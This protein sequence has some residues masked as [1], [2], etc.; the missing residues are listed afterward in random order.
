M[1][2][3]LAK[4][5]ELIGTLDPEEA[6]T[7]PTPQRL[8]ALQEPLLAHHPL[9]PLAVDLAAQ[10]L[11]RQGGHHPRPVR[12]VGMGDIHAQPVDRIK[13]GTPR[14]RRSPFSVSGTARI[15]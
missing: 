3:R 5:E 1:K 8:V 15:G 2:R 10:L 7:T 11:T 13:D 4:A 14:C 9:R 12:W 6:G